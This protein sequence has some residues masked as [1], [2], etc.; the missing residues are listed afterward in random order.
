[1]K[2]APTPFDLVGKG[3]KAI[4]RGFSYPF[5]WAGGQIEKEM[6]MDKMKDDKAKEAGKKLNA[7]FSAFKYGVQKRK[8]T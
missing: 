7:D 3:L 1:M 4:G 2:K 8:I 6:K 5:R